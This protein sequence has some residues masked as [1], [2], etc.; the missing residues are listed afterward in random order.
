[1]RIEVTEHQ[2]Q[3]K[4]CPDCG[5]Q[6]K[7]EYPPHVTQSAQYG[8]RLKAQASYLNNYHFIPLARTAELLG[9]FYGQ[10]PSEGTIIAANDTRTD[11]AKP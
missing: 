11:R 7:G 3:I 10:V 2:A 1:M 9:D 6:V 8:P 5:Q 4:Q